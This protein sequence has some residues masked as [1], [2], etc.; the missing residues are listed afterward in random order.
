LYVQMVGRG[1]RPAPG[2][3][4]CLL[5]DFAGVVM[6]HG[7]VD[8]VNVRGR[9]ESSGEPGEAPVKACPDCRLYLA[10]ATRVCPGCGHEFPPPEPAQKLQPKAFGGAVLSHQQPTELLAVEGMKLERWQGRDPSKPDTIVITYRTGIRDVREWVCPEH[11]GFARGKF[12]ARCVKEWGIKPP[13]DI[14]ETLELAAALPCP[15]AILVRPQKGNAKYLD[16]VRRF[17]EPVEIP[18]EDDNLDL[19][20]Q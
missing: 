19:P 18:E 13:A 2:K 20:F 16:V 15:T 9:G 3:E 6:E 1:M 10:T 12:E 5:L 17:Y 8:Q 4:D 14:D 7:P 11:V